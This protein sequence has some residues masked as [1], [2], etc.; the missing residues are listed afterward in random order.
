M[1]TKL[2]IFSWKNDALI[3]DLVLQY[4]NDEFESSYLQFNFMPNQAT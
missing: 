2:I 1:M 4:G 3:K